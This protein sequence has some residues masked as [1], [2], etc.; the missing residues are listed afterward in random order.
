[1]SDQPPSKPVPTDSAQQKPGL[2]LR[3]LQ[4]RA[5]LGGTATPEQ[6]VAELRAE[7]LPEATEDQ[8][9]QVWDEGHGT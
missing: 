8:V 4:I 3:V 7:G 2:P 9:R 6:V 5:R 1:M